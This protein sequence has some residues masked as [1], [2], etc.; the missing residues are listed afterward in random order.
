MPAGDT[1]V[2]EMQV[3][4]EP[5]E[6]IAAIWA[7]RVALAMATSGLLRDR[8]ATPD[9]SR[10]D[11]LAVPVPAVLPSGGFRM[12]RPNPVPALQPVIG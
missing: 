4:A 5:I 12:E 1:A 7:E 6:K 2:V 9:Q 10:L 8:M 3:H 11:A